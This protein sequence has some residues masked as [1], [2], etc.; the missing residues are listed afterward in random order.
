MA[1][2]DN[3]PWA[4]TPTHADFVLPE[5]EPYIRAFNDT[6]AKADRDHRIDLSLPPE[7]FQGFHDA[8]L[9]LLFA[10]PGRSARTASEPSA[11]RTLKELT[12]AN[13]VT[14]GGVPYYLLDERVESTP[15]GEWTR[16]CLG[17]LLKLGHTYEDLSRLVMAVEF[18]GYHSAKWAAPPVTLPSQHFGFDL[19]RSAMN[20]GATIVVARARRYWYVAV[21]GLAS[22]KG[23]IT[24]HTQRSSNISEGN[25]GEE[26]FAKVE[27]CLV[28]ATQ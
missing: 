7:P 18:H 23:I 9:V 6:F 11:E 21:P 19:V 10:N 16:R 12:R 2:G 13:L 3:N 1:A 15:G 14:P 17:G 22:Y 26:G 24:T 25:L 27:K 5:D 8:P 28:A 4:S 20:R